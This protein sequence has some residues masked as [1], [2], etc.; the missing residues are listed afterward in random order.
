[1]DNGGENIK[2]EKRTN[3]KD[4]K[5]GIAFK[6]TARDTPQQNSLAEIGLTVVANKACA[7]RAQANIP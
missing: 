5:L 1:M 4:W 7:M 2:F 3:S 6:K